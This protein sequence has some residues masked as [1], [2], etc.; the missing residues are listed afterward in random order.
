MTLLRVRTR[1]Y[2]GRR[3]MTSGNTALTAAATT[4]DNAQQGL[5]SYGCAWKRTP[6]VPF[7]MNSNAT[8]PQKRPG[9]RC[10]IFYFSRAT[11]TR[12]ISHIVFVSNVLFLDLCLHKR[13]DCHLRNCWKRSSIAEKLFERSTQ[14]AGTPAPLTRFA[15]STCK[16][17]K[18]GSI[19][20][21]V[22]YRGTRWQ[23]GTHKRISR[24]LSVAA[25][26]SQRVRQSNKVRLV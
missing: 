1:G 26:D 5:V 10:N 20:G 7:L 2:I 11:A 9:R 4:V 17:K 19:D 16:T 15:I 8:C 14:S 22:Q 23:V 21:C 12:G 18:H 24:L 6:Y 25:D 13:E 3:A